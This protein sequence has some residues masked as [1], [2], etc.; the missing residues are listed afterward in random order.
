[1]EKGEPLSS[2]NVLNPE[3]GCHNWKGHFC[4]STVMAKQS[5]PLLMKSITT[6]PW[7]SLYPIAPPAAYQ[8]VT[9]L[10]SGWGGGELLAVVGRSVGS[11][12]WKGTATLPAG[13]ST[14]LQALEALRVLPICLLQA[15]VILEA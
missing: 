2:Q 8:R 3:R 14:P 11:K 9:I 6:T 13:L 15:I 4:V 10:I 5:S 1:M 12:T 7:G